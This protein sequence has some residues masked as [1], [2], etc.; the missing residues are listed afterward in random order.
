MSASSCVKGNHS[1]GT[2]TTSWA[3][4]KTSSVRRRWQ[5]S[6]CW[7]LQLQSLTLSQAPH[8][9]LNLVNNICKV[10]KSDDA[11]LPR[12]WQEVTNACSKYMETNKKDWKN[13]LPTHS[14]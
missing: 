4:E 10:L 12:Q 2:C 5:A 7:A 8:D 3:D 13:K 9:D 6:T 11:C 14:G 1:S